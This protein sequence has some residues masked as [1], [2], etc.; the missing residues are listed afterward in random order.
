MRKFKTIPAS[1]VDCGHL[2][3]IAGIQYHVS[4]VGTFPDGRVLIAADLPRENYT[5]PVSFVKLELL[6]N[7]PM[8]IR[9][10]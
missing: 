4:L 1:E 3:D 10:K 9:R 5:D 7:V 6:P 2:L 8:K